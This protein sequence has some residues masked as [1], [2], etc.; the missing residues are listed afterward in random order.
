MDLGPA[1]RPTF[2]FIGVTT[3]KS[4][5]MKVFPAWAR[6]L[7]LGDCEIRGIDCKW[8]DAPEVYRAVVTFLKN[9]SLSL[10]ALVTRW[11]A[12]AVATSSSS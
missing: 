8:H 5:I 7:N 11:S 4:S 12:R 3:A 9:D 10:G 2:Y 1:T 6:Q